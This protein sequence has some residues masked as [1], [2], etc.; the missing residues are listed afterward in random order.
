MQYVEDNCPEIYEGLQNG[1]LD[2]LNDAVNTFYK[3]INDG[4]ELYCPTK[5][6]DKRKVSDHTKAWWDKNCQKHKRKLTK[7]KSYVRLPRSNC[8]T[9]TSHNSASIDITS[10][11]NFPNAT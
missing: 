2:T 6:I 4:L 1:T 11:V 3:T 9:Q 5:I 8:S 10:Y 7:I